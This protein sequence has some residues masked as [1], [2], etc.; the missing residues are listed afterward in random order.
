LTRVWR[1]HLVFFVGYVDAAP[2]Y[3]AGTGVG[4]VVLDD[5]NFH[6]SVRLDDFESER[7]LT[8]VSPFLALHA[9]FLYLR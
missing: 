5:C 8:L 6:E 3:S 1:A 2:D 4:L 7:A 9:E